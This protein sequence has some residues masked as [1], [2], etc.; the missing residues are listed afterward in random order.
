MLSQSHRTSQ[1]CFTFNGLLLWGLFLLFSFHEKALAQSGNAALKQWLLDGLEQQ[2][3]KESSVFP[4]G[5]FPSWR[6]YALNGR[7]EKADVN[8]FFTGLIDFTLLNIHQYFN[9]DQQQQIE[10]IRK[11]CQ[12]IYPKFANRRGRPT[13]NFWPTDTPRIFPN[14]GWLN[15]FD[16]QQALPDDADDTVILLLAQQANDSSASK[17]HRLLRDFANGQQQTINNT[18]KEFQDLPAYST[19]FGKKM[20]VDF[21]V[22]VLTNILYFV[23]KYR[24]PWN[25]ADSAS[26]YL[27]DQ[28]IAKDLYLTDPAFVSPHYQRVPVILYHFSRLMQLQPL[29]LLEKHKDKLVK[30]TIDRLSKTTDYLDAV[31]L[32]TALLRWNIRYENSRTV[33]FDRWSAQ[34][35]EG[36]FSF[37]VANMSSM[38]PGSLKSSLDKAALGKFYYNCPAYHFALVLENIIW[39]EIRENQQPVSS[40]NSLP[41]VAL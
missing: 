39:Q 21:D 33:D 24:L 29:P 25:D 41:P 13:Y 16:R 11:G 20:P 10:K 14:G 8:P 19:W 27:I 30:E 2:Q 36:P 12:Q 35:R 34:I 5:S 37:F 4:A 17:V 40:R 7:V 28:L 23:L 15:W 18:Y 1:H 31:L 38:L 22:C 9:P 26:L 32:H 3:V 6:R